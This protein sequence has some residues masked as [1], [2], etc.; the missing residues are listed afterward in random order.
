MAGQKKAP[1]KKSNK[2]TKTRSKASS[3]TVTEGEID[4]I[5]QTDIQNTPLRVW[6]PGMPLEEGEELQADPSAYVMLHSFSLGWPCLSFDFI[7]TGKTQTGFPLDLS[8]VS[9]TQA[10]DGMNEVLVVNWSNSPTLFKKILM[11]EDEEEYAEPLMKIDRTSHDGAV[12][13]VRHNGRLAA[14]W[15]EQG[16]VHIWDTQRLLNVA[17]VREHGKEGYCFS[18]EQESTLIR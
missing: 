13:R 4:D 6:L 12:N 14:T 15:S 17:S 2:H 9:G 5:H 10:G 16:V 3:L 11:I 18:M 1:K 7:S 8:V